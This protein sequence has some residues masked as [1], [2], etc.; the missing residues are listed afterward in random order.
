MEHNFKNKS[1][2][3]ILII[4]SFVLNDSYYLIILRVERDLFLY[5]GKDQED[6]K[7]NNI[8]FINIDNY[9]NKT[10][11]KANYDDERTN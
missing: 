7:Q 5:L 8:V 3:K 4:N 9:F 6:E 11:Y 1:Y 2:S 10:I